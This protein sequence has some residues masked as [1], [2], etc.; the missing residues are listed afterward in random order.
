M[1]DPATQQY[2]TLI[3]I[4]FSERPALFWRLYSSVVDSCKPEEAKKYYIM[5][6]K[7]REQF[8]NQIMEVEKLRLAETV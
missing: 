5:Q 1:Y 6:A 8:E 7:T 2:V 4:D 3:K